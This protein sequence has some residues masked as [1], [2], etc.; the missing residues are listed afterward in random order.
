MRPCW[1]GRQNRRAK[2]KQPIAMSLTI[3]IVIDMMRKLLL[4]LML[5][6]PFSFSVDI[7]ETGITCQNLKRGDVIADV[8]TQEA[9]VYCDTSKPIIESK[10][11]TI[12]IKRYTC[13]YNGDA[14][15]GFVTLAPLQEKES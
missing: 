2:P 8:S 7:C 12:Y 11:R 4:A 6:S 1:A 5:T 9:A 13:I 3:K 15:E 14:L 10:P